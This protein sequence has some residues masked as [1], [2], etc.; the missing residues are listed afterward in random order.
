MKNQYIKLSS[1]KMVQPSEIKWHELKSIY[2]NRVITHPENCKRFMR[3]ASPEMV[4]G[5]VLYA[6]AHNSTSKHQ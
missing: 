2:H 1:G 3:N 4:H 5:V 6:Q